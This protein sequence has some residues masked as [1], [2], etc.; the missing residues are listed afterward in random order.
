AETREE[1]VFEEGVQRLFRN[2]RRSLMATSFVSSSGV[3]LMGVTS[4]ALMYVGGQSILEGSMTVGEFLAFTLYLGILVAPVMQ[5]ANVG[6]QLTEAFAGLDRTNELLAEA[7]EG[8]DPRRT[9]SLPRIEGDLH[10]RDVDFEYD[11]G[12]PILESVDFHAKPGSVTALVGSSG[13]GKSTIFGLAA[14][15]MK[16]TRGTVEVD[17]VDLSTV[18]LD[19]YRS[20]L[21]LVLQDDFLFEGSIRDN[22]R[23]G[24]PDA[25]EEELRRATRLAFVDEFADQYE[26]GLETVIGER[27]IKLSGGQRQRVAI[28]RAILSDPRILFLDE[29]TSSLDTESER[30]IQESLSQLMEGRTT[31]VIAHRLSTIRRADQILVIEG[32]KVIERGTHDDLIESRGRYHDLYTYQARI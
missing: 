16:P 4:A 10:F 21:G 24:R 12:K 14:A 19:D 6:T 11:P 26:D 2:I 22:V 30:Y 13:S 27:G 1:E 7:Q 5:I 28:A 23:F 18:R 20:Q 15:F 9:I 25:T 3:F 32:G 17:G 29:A 8:D 31:F